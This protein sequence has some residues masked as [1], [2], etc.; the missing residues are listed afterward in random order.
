LLMLIV[1]SLLAIWPVRRGIDAFATRSWQTIEISYVG[2][3]RVPENWV[4]TERGGIIYFTDREFSNDETLDDVTLYMFLRSPNVRTWEAV[5]G[6]DVTSNIFF[7][8]VRFVNDINRTLVYS[9]PVLGS[10]ISAYGNAIFEINGEERA[11]MEINMEAGN[12]RV[13]SLRAFMQFVIWDESVSQ[14]TVRRIARSYRQEPS[15]PREGSTTM[16]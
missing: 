2:S 5:R 14:A 8:S 12:A 9:P 3:L 15:L 13:G 4:F 7:E 10:P 16:N 1:I 6:G 11:R